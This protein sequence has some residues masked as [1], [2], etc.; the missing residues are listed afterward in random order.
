MRLRSH[1]EAALTYTA[2]TGDYDPLVAFADD[3]GL[4]I[5]EGTL[6]ES[7]EPDSS[8]G[9]LTPSQAGMLAQAANVKRLVVSHLWHERPDEAVVSAVRSTFS[10]EVR[11]AKPGLVIHV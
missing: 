4:L 1:D 2:D 10:G 6:P 11:I 5:A 7:D 9:H 3:S 8:A